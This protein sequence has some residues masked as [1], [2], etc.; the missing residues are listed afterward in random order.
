MIRPFVLLAAASLIAL[1]GC[2]KHEER[3]ASTLTE[4]QRDTAI[5]RSVLPGADVVG[6]AL[7]VSGRESRR[8]SGMDSLAN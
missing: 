8:A 6:R 3:P 1:A 7:Q 4:A 2:S 5:A